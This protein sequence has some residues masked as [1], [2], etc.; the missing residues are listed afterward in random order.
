MLS[1]DL[2]TASPGSSAKQYVTLQTKCVTSARLSSFLTIDLPDF[3]AGKNYVLI[4]PTRQP[5]HVDRYRERV[6]QRILTVAVT[7]PAL[8]AIQSGEQPTEGDLIRLERLLHNELQAGDIYLT[9]KVARQAFGIKLNGRR[10]FLGLARQVLQLDAIPDYDIV[11]SRALKMLL[12]LLSQEIR[13]D[14]F[15]RWRMS[16]WQ[17][18]GYQKPICMTPLTVFGRNAADR[19]FRPEQIK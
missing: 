9:E 11:V 4:G 13:Y 14:F 19:L 12:Q 10:G 15:V 16:S 1:Q 6:E 3:I 17:G 18:V 2:A 5:V 7:D 8:Q